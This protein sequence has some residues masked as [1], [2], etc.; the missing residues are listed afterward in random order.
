V[1]HSQQGSALLLALM[2][3]IVLAFLGIGLLLQTSLGL[4][5]SGADRWVVK[6]LY[7]ADAGV[8]ME[9]QM[10]KMNQMNTTDS[11]GNALTFQLEEDASVAGL[12]RGEYQ[13]TLEMI[14]E[15]LPSTRVMGWSEDFRRR[16]FHMRSHAERRIGAR[17]QSQATVQADLSMGPMSVHPS[18][19]VPMETICQ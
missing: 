9:I 2:V 13:V 6:S 16:Y 1:D 14:C 10:L 7:A 5:A 17:V 19:F 15:I 8:Q 3:S 18:N 11:S 12:L 4:E